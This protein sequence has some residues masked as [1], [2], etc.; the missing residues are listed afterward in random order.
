MQSHST[1]EESLDNEKTSIDLNVHQ[2]NS[3][4][5][6]PSINK[7]DL[8]EQG[9]LSHPI[10]KNGQQ[11]LVTWTPEEE[12]AIVRKIDFLFLPIF[13]L[14]FTWMAIDRTNVSSVLTSTFL[15]DTSITPDEANAGISILWLGIVLLEIPSN[16][17]LHRIG[18]HYWL[19]AQVVV[20]GL[21]EVLHMFVTN[22][23]G[24]YAARLFLGLTESGFIPGGLY[25]L[26]RWYVPN[27]L[28]KRTAIFFLGPALA[29]AFGSLI[30]AGALSLHLEGGLTGW[31]WIFIICGVSTIAAG[32]L[33]FAIVPKSPYHTGYLFGGL[34]R[35]K[36]WLSEHEADILIA[37]Q[38]RREDYQVAGDTLK[39]GWK[40]ITDVLFHWATWPYLIVCLT[41]LQSVNGLGTWGAS[42][43]TSLNF[44]AIRANLLNAPGNLLCAIFGIALSAYVD[45][46][47]RFGYAIIFSAVWTLAGLVALYCLPITSK[48]SWS[49]YAAYLVTQSAPNWQP[50][51]VTW[52]SLNFKTPQKRAIAYAV[53]IGCSHL[54]GTY[55]NQVFR[56]S[57]APLYRTAWIACISLGAVWLAG[58]IAQTFGFQWAN[59]RFSRKLANNPELE[60]EIAYIDTKGRKHR[61]HW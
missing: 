1:A 23:S 25:T 9:T 42:I 21:V 48:A 56:A 57:D 33:A 41:G 31:Q 58:I 52:L 35:V 29:A 50:I 53:Y 15:S 22:A 38:A 39:I 55:G 18:P 17:V 8:E 34:I 32:V 26:S 46:Y 20:W 60:S 16:I 4:T 28:A 3:G 44:S 6:T 27:E 49:F 43:I 10:S 59:R 54:G 30:C 37:R 5:N 45:R 24:W 7:S 12:A 40:D 51:N 36:G 2:L 14:L 19:P 13:S 11:I 61:Y 47:S